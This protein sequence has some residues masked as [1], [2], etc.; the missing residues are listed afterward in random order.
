MR[1]GDRTGGRRVKFNHSPTFA[2]VKILLIQTAF[3]GDVIL[4]TALLEEL[5]T[6]RRGDAVDMLVRRGNE[7]LLANHPHVGRV[8][9]WDKKRGKYRSLVGLFKELQLRQYDA[10]VNL[11]RFGATGLLTAFTGARQR[12][13]FDKNPF[14]FA[15]SRKLPHRIDPGGPFVHEIDRNRSLIAHWLPEDAPR[16]GPA[17]YPTV[18]D[19]QRVRT[20]AP[21]VCLAPTSVWFT[22]QWPAERWSDLIDLLPTDHAI[23]LLGAPA[24]RVA[25]QAIIAASQRPDAQNRAGE[26]SLLESAALMQ[27][28]RMNYVNDSAPLHL[29]SAV[30]APVTAVF[31]STVPGF[32]FT[33]LSDESRVV[34][35]A[36][37]LPCRPCGLHGKAACPE[38]HFR[39]ADIAPARVRGPLS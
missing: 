7:V 6:H 14:S 30:N 31:C 21:Y 39:C 19:R 8:L 10:I 36:G 24:D 37:D 27:H 4:A 22:K 29:A 1:F 23:Y 11:Q 3:I 9:T 34:E 5:V 38:G 17:L 25:C 32:G 12:I 26:L 35:H 18:A 2:R 28:A 20:E 15:Y 33:P 13:G 16:Q